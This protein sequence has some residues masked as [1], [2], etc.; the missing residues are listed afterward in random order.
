MNAN[1]FAGLNSKRSIE[2]LDGIVRLQPVEWHWKK[3][4]EDPINNN[5]N[6]NNT[7]IINNNNEKQDQKHTIT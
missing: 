3:K 5:N 2:L 6:N 7:N 4:K 1:D